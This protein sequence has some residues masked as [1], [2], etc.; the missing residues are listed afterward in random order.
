MRSVLRLKKNWLHTGAL[1]VM[2]TGLLAGQAMA[3]AIIYNTGDL[4][5]ATIALGVNDEGHLNV[6]DPTG[7]FDPGNAG[8]TGIAAIG[9]GD[10]TSPGCLCEGWGVSAAL[11]GGSSVT[12][13]ANE[14]IGGVVN[15]TVESFSTDAGAGTGSSATSVTSLTD[16]PGL[17]VEHAY[18]TSDAAPGELFETVVTITNDTG[19]VVNDLR[20]VRVMD[21][22]V[23]PTE[24]N[25]FVTIGGA[26]AT[27]FLETSHDGGFS[28][29]DPLGFDSPENPATVN[30]DFTDDGPD[31][32]GAYFRFNF[33]DLAD[34]ESR[35]FNIY[36]GAAPTE[37]AALTALGDE[38]IELFSFGQNSD[39]DGATIGGPA[40]FIFGFASV[41]GT[42]V[43]TPPSDDQ[44]TAV[45]E[46]GTL[47]MLG[48]GLLGMGTLLRRR[49]R[50]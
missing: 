29:P 20:Y 19:S 24:F 23:P 42:P 38:G 11:D 50:R 45:P 5:T 22:D 36:Y 46:P 32:H 14:D 21:W 6:V 37:A 16:T 18:G 13:H 9:I 40:T 35:E 4:A 34:G 12:G 3:A 48:A 31:D 49:R 39:P 33:G 25:E 17:V 47:G 30:V 41:G 8:A 28:T 27:S 44:P 43:V 7:T 1:T 10:A 2:A 15:L 26:A